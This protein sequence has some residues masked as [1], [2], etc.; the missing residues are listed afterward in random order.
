VGQATGSG[1]TLV[2]HTAPLP[3]TS[4]N[5]STS[6]EWTAPAG[7]GG[8]ITFWG[9]INA[10]DGNNAYNN[11]R[12][13][14]GVSL[15]LQDATTVEAVTVENNF[16]TYPNP[17]TDDLNIKTGNAAPGLYTVKAF[18]LYGK[19]IVEQD[20]NVVPGASTLALHTGTWASGCY[21]LQITKDDHPEMLLVTKR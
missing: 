11:D 6:F 13:S 5:Y 8:A 19:K 9:I 14:A 1:V 18:D 20:V 12:P 3:G 21:L 15:V 10:V 17:F 7:G 16:S 2:E 4:G